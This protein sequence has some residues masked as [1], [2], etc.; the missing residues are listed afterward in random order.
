MNTFRI[1]IMMERVIPGK[2]TGSLDRAYFQDLK[3]VHTLILIPEQN[4]ENTTAKCY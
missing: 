2:M 1:N 4:E 3:N